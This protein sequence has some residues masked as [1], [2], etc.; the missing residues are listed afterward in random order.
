M[1]SYA[2]DRQNQ[3]FT[4]MYSFVDYRS[5]KEYIPSSGSVYDII[6]KNSELSKF[7]QLVD[8]ANMKEMLDNPQFNCTVLVCKDKDFNLNLDILDIGSAKD[9]LN[10]CILQ[11]K[12]NK[13]LLT[14]S[15]V[16]YYYTRNLYMRLYIINI[17]GITRIN[18][19]Y[20]ITDFD[21]DCNNGMI[22]ICSGLIVPSG[23]HFM[24]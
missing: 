13:Y 10:S 16:A 1:V 18:N 2:P 23:E 9:I 4:H 15:P 22:H 14:S 12:I 21:I 8:R 6:Y 11:R 20:N 5:P 7:K 24:N 3:N 19:C 17:G